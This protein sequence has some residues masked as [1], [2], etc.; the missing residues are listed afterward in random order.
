MLVPGVSDFGEDLHA[1]GQHFK[2]YVWLEKVQLLPYHTLGVHKYEALGWDYQLKD[3]SEN[4]PEQKKRAEEILRSYFG[5]K[6]E[7]H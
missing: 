2:D 3:V 1:L 6:L 5:Q 7:V 4:T